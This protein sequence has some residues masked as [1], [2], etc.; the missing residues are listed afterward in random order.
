[1]G[2]RPFSWFPKYREARPFV[3]PARQAA[4][5]TLGLPFDAVLGI[6]GQPILRQLV[7]TQQMQTQLMGAQVYDDVYGRGGQTNYPTRQQAL[8]K[9]PLGNPA[10]T[11]IGAPEVGSI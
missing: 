3:E 10:T 1:M 11:V 4:Y 7:A 2:F 9:N 8:T 6:G 5:D